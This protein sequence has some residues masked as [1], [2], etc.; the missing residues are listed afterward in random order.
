MEWNLSLNPSTENPAFSKAF[1][2]HSPTPCKKDFTWS[3]FL[4]IKIAAK[5]IAANIPITIPAGL[6]I[7]PTTPPKFPIIRIAVPNTFVTPPTI[8]TIFPKTI[9][10]GPAAAAIAPIFTMALTWLSLNPFSRSPD[11]PIISD[12]F[13]NTGVNATPNWINEF[14][15]LLIDI[16]IRSVGVSIFSYAAWVAPPASAIK[17]RA[18]AKSADPFPAN[19]VILFNASVDPNS[20]A[21]TSAFPLVFS[22]I[23]SKNFAHPTLCRW[24]EEKSSPNCCATLLASVDGFK[25]L[26]YAAFKPVTA[27]LVAIPFLV[28]TATLLNNSSVDTFKLEAIGITFPMLLAISPKEVLPKFCAINIWSLILAALD[29]SK[30]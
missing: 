26:L 22:L 14:F 10:A 1:L 7:N 5:E 19:T 8:V 30:P 15:N 20:L 25:I 3:Q 13:S 23:S 28:S 11:F 18:F 21:I 29:A 24:A 2:N 17:L 16:F 4:M 27:S 12:I 9:K 6:V